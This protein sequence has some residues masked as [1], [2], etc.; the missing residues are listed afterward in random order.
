MK[1][2]V[3]A[4]LCSLI[5]LIAFG[6][7]RDKETA[8]QEALA[9]FKSK[10]IT[11]SQVSLA[12]VA[13]R[14]VNTS[15]TSSYYIFNAGN[16]KGFVIISGNDAV[17]KVLGY[18]DTGSFDTDNIPDNVQNWLN[19]YDVTIKNI[20]SDAP[21]APTSVAHTRNVINPICK[22][23]WMQNN[24][25]NKF[26]PSAPTGCTATAMAQVMYTHKWPQTATTTIPSYTEVYYNKV[27][28]EALDPVTFDWDNMLLA[29]YSNTVYTDEQ[30]TAIGRLM[31][32][33]GRSA[34]M[35]YSTS[36]SGAY[37][38]DAAYGLA[39]Y[40]GYDKC[41]DY[42]RDSYTTNAWND[43]IYGELAEG[44]AVI[45]SG[46][47]ASEAGHTFVC[48]GYQGD[49]YFHI[50]WG[51][52]GSCNGY[53]LLSLLDFS[54]SLSYSTKQECIINLTPD[55]N[56]GEA[57]TVIP[58]G[59]VLRLKSMSVSPS[60]V[61]RDDANSAFVIS[62]IST[63]VCN[64]SRVSRN[65]DA[66][67]GLFDVSGNLIKVLTNKSSSYASSPFYYYS[68]G[69]SDMYSKVSIESDVAD[70]TYYIKAISR[71][72]GESTWIEDD[73]SGKSYITAVISKN[74]LTLGD[75]SSGISLSVTGQTIDGNLSTGCAQTIN[76]TVKNQSA[77]EYEGTLYLLG[78]DS[79]NTTTSLTSTTAT[80]PANQSAVVS[81]SYTP[82]A[83]GT[84]DL[85]VST[86]SSISE[87]L[88]EENKLDSA[89][90]HE[91][92]ASYKIS[93]NVVPTNA[94]YDGTNADGYKTYTLYG[95]SL[96]TVLNVAN[97]GEAIFSNL[98]DFYLYNSSDK[99]I[100]L[101]SYF[102]RVEIDGGTA[103]TSNVFANTLTC[104]NGSY[105][106][107]A[108]YRTGTGSS[109]EVVM[110]QIYLNITDGV[111]A[112]K[113]DGTASGVAIE[114]NG[115]KVPS[116]IV[117]VNL[118]DSTGLTIT[119]NDNPNTLY[120]ISSDKDVPAALSGK[121]VVK[122]NSAESVTLEDGYDY[123]S[124]NNFTAKKITFTRTFD[125]TNSSTDASVKSGIR[126]LILPFAPDNISSGSQQLS[127]YTSDTD[128]GKDFW[129]YD[130]NSYDAAAQKI[131]FKAGDTFHANR[132]YVI[133][134]PSGKETLTFS[135][136]NASVK[137][138]A[139]TVTTGSNYSFIGTYY[140]KT[141]AALENE[142]LYVPNSAGTGF[143][144]TS[145]VTV[146]PFSAYFVSTAQETS[147]LT[148]CFGATETTGITSV[149]DTQNA[150]AKVYSVSGVMVNGSAD[151]NNPLE[152]LPRGIYIVNGKKVVK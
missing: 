22:T 58:N 146:N 129:L 32:Y 16:D 151:A 77:N 56:P 94:V 33:C 64:S 7:P 118:G 131:Y 25:F 149:A 96:K 63:I 42:V 73:G 124:P 142:E 125:A 69:T 34:K 93:G 123:Y 4:S 43:L 133:A 90:F 41:K 48:D 120:F 72:S 105:K 141:V 78:T 117:A 130:F 87:M 5:F 112:W 97:T 20:K 57:G 55:A 135:A 113:A 83:A 107:I 2:L 67:L 86:S 49:D 74:K 12:K 26:C 27:T 84:Y 62:M 71:A 140:K 6:T 3:L 66:G 98:I 29:Y 147:P 128:T 91:A 115:I 37:L 36:A 134:V 81:F 110:D 19:C 61:T 100:R 54:S 30:G 119:P 82:T 136:E 38:C 68:N 52:G 150:K 152:G 51:W 144:E 21:V 95:K 10:N 88:T 137:G 132:P 35:S 46:Y 31:E 99:N 59:D 70:G 148:F 50:N 60:S 47:T 85:S 13:A 116:G 138:A 1:R 111:P 8:Q 126:T 139:T 15:E 44:R 14:S 145:S 127:W 114:S 23:E 92:T 102:E 40:L 39:N 24:P 17:P 28:R 121:N 101:S 122:G 80:I 108:K 76:M 75:N 65:F 103:Y 143:G 79:E 18:S 9:F 104:D 45:Y 11:V 53:Y 89:K 106:I 109:T